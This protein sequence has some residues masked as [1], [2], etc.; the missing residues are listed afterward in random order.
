MAT[1]LVAAQ[2]SDSGQR[3]LLH[4]LV[5]LT[6]SD[7]IVRHRLRQLE[8]PVAGI[9]LGQQ[10]GTK[11]TAEHAFPAKLKDGL[12]D[13]TDD[14]TSKRIAQCMRFGITLRAKSLLIIDKEVHQNPALEVVG[15]FTLCPEAGPLPEHATLH[16][17]LVSLYADNGIML[18]IHAA[19][20][21]TIDGTKGKV[22]VSV[23]ESISEG[24]GSATENAM[25]VD[26]K[27]GG[28]LQFRPV[29]FVIETDETEMIAINYVAK[30]A[31]SAAAV[32]QTS[33][34]NSGQ[35]EEAKPSSA[36][37]R[38]ADQKNTSAQKP[39]T[40]T[41]EEEDQIA[42]M[43]T[44][45]NSVRMLQ[46][47]IQLMSR[48]VESTPLSYLS[49]QT[50]ALSPTSPSPDHLA[51]LRNIQA[52]LSRLSLL[53]P[54][55]Q[56]ESEALEQAGRAQS[57]DVFITSI[58]SMLGQDVQGLSELGRKFTT[59]E[60]AKSSRSKNKG[61]FTQGAFGTMDDFNGLSNRVDIDT[62]LMM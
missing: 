45:L 46:E 54:A 44:R 48:L 56:G 40:L 53:T 6:A 22:P 60:Q 10:Q 49:D 41:P 1:S 51:Q 5:L 4:P 17:Q 58:L 55:G 14:W 24:E 52:L 31:G 38:S 18:A 33:Q 21:S 26:G 37:T 13:Q 50:I 8:G 3:V 30:G 59:I 23:Y 15:W 62:G 7:L 2:T 39:P 47:R 27:E 12:L 29:P 16:K 35:A 25:Q 32:S 61:V 34:W 11:A 19:G 36:K 42:G 9:L 20:F 43:A 57:N 28:S